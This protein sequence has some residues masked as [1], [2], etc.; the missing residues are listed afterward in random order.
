MKKGSL[1]SIQN[2]RM[3]LHLITFNE[4]QS[5]GCFLDS[6]FHAESS[7]DTVG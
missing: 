1:I 4:I 6:F 3:N 5:K 2:S 7:L